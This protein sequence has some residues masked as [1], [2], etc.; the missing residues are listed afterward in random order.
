MSQPF[1]KVHSNFVDVRGGNI[2]G[3]ANDEDNPE[4][5]VATSHNS[6]LTNTISHVYKVSKLYVTLC[7]YYHFSTYSEFHRFGP[8]KGDFK[9]I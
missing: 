2:F 3:L 1:G 8:R 7:T 6:Y 4:S 9:Q 5:E